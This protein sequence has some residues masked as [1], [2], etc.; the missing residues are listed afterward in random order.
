MCG[1]YYVDDETAREI[2][3]LV[4]EIDNKINRERLTGD[5]YPTSQAMVLVSR[6]RQVLPVRQRFG[7]ENFQKKGVIFNARSE[8]VLQKPLFRESILLRRAV[9]PCSGFYEWS[10]NKE[11]AAFYREHHPTMF[12]AGFYQRAEEDRFVI[13]TTNANSF[14]A[15]VHDRM[16]LILEKDEIRDWLS[17]KEAFRD[18]LEERQIPLKRR[19]EYEQQE[20]KLF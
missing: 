3:Q 20:L 10:K 4:R 9:I 13:L 11:K 2:E 5:V 7:F 17:D 19:Q 16:P 6:D 12:L 8:S 18:M 1:R 15:P 14:V